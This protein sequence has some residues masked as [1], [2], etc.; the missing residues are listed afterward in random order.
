VA[1]SLV[2]AHASSG[3]VSTSAAERSK[4]MSLGVP[5]SKGG[6]VSSAPS[7]V[8]SP[9]PG[10][11]SSPPCDWL[12]SPSAQPK[13]RAASENA[14]WGRRSTDR[15]YTTRAARRT[16]ASLSQSVTLET[17]HDRFIL[18]NTALVAPPLLPEIRLHL[19]TEITPLWTK[20]QAWLDERQIAPP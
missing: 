11:V 10:P 1:S 6:A 15:R 16:C 7:R 8:A 2:L 13:R 19:A 4:P 20:T 9:P 5:E 17:L 3:P 12:F 14:T 18:E